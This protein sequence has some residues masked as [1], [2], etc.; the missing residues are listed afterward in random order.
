MVRWICMHDLED[1][2]DL[3]ASMSFFVILYQD[4]NSPLRS[5]FAGVCSIAV[6]RMI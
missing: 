6:L 3:G 1:V 5:V 4:C 2:R